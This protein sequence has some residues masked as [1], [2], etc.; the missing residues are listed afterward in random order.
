M[1]NSMCGSDFEKSCKRQAE[2]GIKGLDIK[3]GLWGQTIK[4]VSVENAQRAADIAKSNSLA[5]HNLSFQICHSYLNVG[6]AAFRKRHLP[7]SNP[8]LSS[9]RFTS[10]TPSG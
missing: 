5:V 6:E 3:D 7:P 4:D 8:C 10:R 1:L 9:R 2:L